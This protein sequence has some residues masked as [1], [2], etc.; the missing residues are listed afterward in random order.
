M[1]NNKNISDNLRDYIPFPY[2]EKDAEAF[3]GSCSKENPTVTFGVVYDG[4]LV[5]CAGLV[6]QSDVYRLSAEIG[7][8]LGEPYW[9]LGIATRAVKLVINYGFNDLKLIRI[10][11]GIFSFNKKSQ[12]VLE[13]AGFKRECVFEKAIIKN[14]VICDEYRYGLTVNNFLS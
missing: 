14:G 5:G 2:T 8:W 7:Y 1:C 9:G 11:S 13:K 4:V 10:Y 12:R 6:P 3:I